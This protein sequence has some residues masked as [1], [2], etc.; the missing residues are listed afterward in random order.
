MRGAGA[1]AAAAEEASAEALSAAEAAADADAD[2]APDKMRPNEGRRRLPV[3]ALCFN[4]SYS[5]CSASNSSFSLRCL[6]FFCAALNCWSRAWNSGSVRLTHSKA[7]A[8]R[9]A[10][11]A[12]EPL[13]LALALDFFSLHTFRSHTSGQQKLMTS[14][15]CMD[16]GVCVSL[17]F[18]VRIRVCRGGG[19]GALF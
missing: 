18:G 16:G 4:S 11:P 2:A 12:P 5:A 14:M 17:R 13:P 7:N 3:P 1:S 15:W 8:P 19:G 10:L 9:H 6:Y